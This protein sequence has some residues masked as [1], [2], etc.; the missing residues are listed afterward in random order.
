MEQMA[1]KDL[2]GKLVL[3]VRTEKMVWLVHLDL[4]ERQDL[5]EQ[6]ARM[7]KMGLMGR[8]VKMDPQVHPDRQV[9]ITKET[10]GILYFFISYFLFQ[11]F[12]FHFMFHW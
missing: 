11:R 6:Q 3:R 10:S 5:L 12:Y 9:N 2:Q 7:V 4:V 1:H 8:T